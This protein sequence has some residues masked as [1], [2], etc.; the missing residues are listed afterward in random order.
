M[1]ISDWSSDVCSSDLILRAPAIACWKRALVY[2]L[3][4]RAW[5]IVGEAILAQEAA[6]PVRF[7]C[8]AG[9]SCCPTRAAIA[10]LPGPA[11]LR[12][13]DPIDDTGLR[14]A[15]GAGLRI[16]RA[17]AIVVEGGALAL[18]ARRGDDILAGHGVGRGTRHWLAAADQVAAQRSV[19]APVIARVIV[20]AARYIPGLDTA[21]LR[22]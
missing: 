14:S 11:A 12:D 13:L 15:V 19:A 22:R 3:T 10:A 17:F 9:V 2:A 20:V 8:A 4:V 6:S 5:R 18:V 21:K 16:E 7:E 1:R